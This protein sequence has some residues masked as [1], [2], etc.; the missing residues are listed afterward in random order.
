[1]V[2]EPVRWVWGRHGGKLGLFYVFQ[3]ETVGQLSLEPVVQGQLR[4]GVGMGQP[5]MPIGSLHPCGWLA[6]PL[7]C[8][9][10]PP[11]WWRKAGGGGNCHLMPFSASWYIPDRISLELSPR[12]S[13]KSFSKSIRQGDFFSPSVL[14]S[15][16]PVMQPCAACNL[17]WNLAG[18]SLVLC[19]GQG[20]LDGQWQGTPDRDQ[21]LCELLLMGRWGLP[22]D[23]PVRRH[24]LGFVLTVKLSIL[25]N[26]H[27]LP[28]QT[29]SLLQ[30]VSK[31]HTTLP[32]GSFDSFSFLKS[33]YYASIIISAFILCHW[34]T[35][36]CDCI[37]SYFI[38]S[39]A[40][41]LPCYYNNKTVHY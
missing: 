27:F 25:Q 16:L 10:R 21:S 41:P 6:D 14:T 37:N 32:W 7:M 9:T 1:M 22:F 35:S 29:K 2:G 12:E 19:D 4:A 11:S 34:Q 33:R 38:P 23:T 24:G 20:G 31:H 30:K 13:S 36:C 15:S 40:F 26:G 5:G 39:T 3:M 18:V 28:D 8:H 17:I